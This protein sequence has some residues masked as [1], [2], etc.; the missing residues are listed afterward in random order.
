MPSHVRTRIGLALVPEC[1]QNMA[2]VQKIL[3]E[4]DAG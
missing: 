2:P 1:G 3:D 4:L